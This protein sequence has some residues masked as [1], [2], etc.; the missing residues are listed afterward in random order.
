MLVEEGYKPPT[1]VE[2]GKK[3]EK[4]FTEWSFDERDLAQLNAKTLNYFF[5]ALKSDDYMRISTCKTGKEI[6]DTLC[7]TYEG[8]NEV[9]QS[10]MI[11]FITV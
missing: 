8:T 6:W 11:K 7:L 1:I 3:V 4:S 9:R 5:C 10:R 2:N